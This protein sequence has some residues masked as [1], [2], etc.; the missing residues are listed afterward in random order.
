MKD[1][2]KLWNMSGRYFALLIN[3]NS[4]VFRK[5]M[6]ALESCAYVSVSIFT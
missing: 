1:P 2:C 5:L 3:L 4:P 6:H